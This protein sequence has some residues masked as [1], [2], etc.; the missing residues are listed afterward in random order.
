MIRS[1]DTPIGKLWLKA[2]RGKLIA[3]AFEWLEEITEKKAEEADKAVLQFAIN[4]LGEYFAGKR[5]RFSINLEFSGTPFREQ[6]WKGVEQ[7][8][9]GKTISYMQLARTAATEKAIRAVGT[10]NGANPLLI[11]VPCHRVIGSNGEL[12][13][14]AGGLERKAWLL[15]HEAFYSGGVL[16]GNE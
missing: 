7:I 9:Y 1:V 4:E 14:Y 13:G 5:T 10:A 11:F 15:K 8:S 2:E 16:F 12:T 6:I 3:A